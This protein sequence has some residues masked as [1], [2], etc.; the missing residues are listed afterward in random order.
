MVRLYFFSCCHM[1]ADQSFFCWKPHLQ[2]ADLWP[3]GHTEDEVNGKNGHGQDEECIDGGVYGVWC[4]GHDHNVGAK[5]HKYERE[6][7]RPLEDVTVQNP[8]NRAIS[9]VSCRG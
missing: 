4:R 7:L 8:V 1:H 9:S 3:A 6:S 5:Q 2:G